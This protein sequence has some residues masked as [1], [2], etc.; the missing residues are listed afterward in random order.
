MGGTS[1][2]AVNFIQYIE[3]VTKVTLSNDIWEKLTQLPLKTVLQEIFKFIKS[4]NCVTDHKLLPKGVSNPHEDN[5][6]VMSPL[7]DKSIGHLFANKRKKQELCSCVH[8]QNHLEKTGYKWYSVQRSNRVH[9]SCNKLSTAQDVIG[10]CKEI[11]LDK[12]S[13]YTGNSLGTSTDLSLAIKWKYN[14]G[15][16]NDAS[17]FLWINNRFGAI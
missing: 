1:F 3:D 2:Q 13:D 17:P 8:F 4:E 11:R 9:V 15:K 14:L 12:C 6:R 10:C 5:K 16:C 7:P